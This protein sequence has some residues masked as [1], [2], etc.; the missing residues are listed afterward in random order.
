MKK[1]LKATVITSFAYFLL[2]CSSRPNSYELDG[3]DLPGYSKNQYYGSIEFSRHDGLMYKAIEEMN[4]L[5]HNPGS[6]TVVSPEALTSNLAI[7]TILP[8]LLKPKID[9]YSEIDTLVQ[10]KGD[11]GKNSLTY[12]VRKF[13]PD[14][15]LTK[16]ELDLQA[17][18]YHEKEKLWAAPVYP[19]FKWYDCGKKLRN[20]IFIIKPVSVFIEM[21]Y[22]PDAD[23]LKKVKEDAIKNSNLTVKLINFDGCFKV[24]KS[25]RSEHQNVD[26]IN[27][28]PY[29]L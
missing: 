13:K 16:I 28:L 23:T 4:F 26:A 10:V 12:K 5:Y 24:V 17:G 14:R 15:P 21:W 25:G 2:S 27:E 29:T 7:Q 6:Y 8:F 3:S 9:T 18:Y 1:I 20:E 19:D 22:I 11:R